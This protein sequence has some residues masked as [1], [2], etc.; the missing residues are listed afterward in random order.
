MNSFDFDVP[1]SCVI[2]DCDGTLVD[3]EI[4][5]HQAI[6]EIF[7]QYGVT[8]D[9][10]ECLDNFQGGKLADVLIQTCERYGL[11]ISIDELER[12]YRKKCKVLFSEHLNPIEGVPELLDTLKKVGIDMCVASNGPVSKMALSLEMTG[13]LHYFRDHLYSAFDAN[14][15]K[16]AP[17]L[18]HYTAM[19]MAV[20]TQECLFVDDTVLG[21]QAGINAGMRTI[22]FNPHQKA[23]IDDPLVISVSSMK[24][25]QALM[26]RLPLS[27]CWA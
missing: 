10:Q 25:L 24:E 13:L 3:S 2:F 23:P 27:D 6:V 22:Y 17:D 18:L 11:S 4:L 12:L 8:L 7:A 16:P 9:L 14:S 26:E 15:W 5:S 1:V 19:N 20:L 21:V